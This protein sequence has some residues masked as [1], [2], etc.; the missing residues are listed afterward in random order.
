MKREILL[1]K[2]LQTIKVDVQNSNNNELTMEKVQN[3]IFSFSNKEEMDTDIL[4]M[5]LENLNSLGIKVTEEP[6][7]IENDFSVEENYVKQYLNDL[8]SYPLLTPEEEKE[9]TKKVKEG[10][11]LAK[12]HLAQSNLRLV[13]SIAKRYN[14][15]GLSFLDL[16]QEGNVGLLKAIDKFN[17]SLGYRFS[18]YATWWIRQ[19]ITRALSDKSRIIRIP[20]YMAEMLNKISNYTRIYSEQYGVNPTDKEIMEYF[21]LTKEK[22]KDIK[23]ASVNVL[24]LEQ[25]VNEDEDLCMKDYVVDETTVNLDDFMKETEEQAVRDIVA[26]AMSKLRPRQQQILE[27]RLGLKDGNPKTLEEVG[28]IFGVTRER[29]RQLEVKALKE[30]RRPKT[31]AQIKSMKK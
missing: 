22:L 30:L 5:V 4:S 8:S 21:D 2:V 10:D 13:V 23:K 12:K 24:S 17:P 14:G 31:M 19:S 29:I 9:L 16:I 7:E 27:Y 25:P 1:K 18:T 6:N 28:Q 3:I 11:K 20:V 26:F 15:N